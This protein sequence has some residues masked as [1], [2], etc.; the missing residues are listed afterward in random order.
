MDI[1]KKLLSEIRKIEKRNIGN[2][3]KDKPVC[4]SSPKYDMQ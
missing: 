2:K 1:N 3:S 4:L